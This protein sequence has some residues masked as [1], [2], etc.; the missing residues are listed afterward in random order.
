MILIFHQ[1]DNLNLLG[2]RDYKGR[3]YILL[4]VKLYLVFRFSSFP[5]THA[6]LQRH[7]IV[8]IVLLK[9]C[10]ADKSAMGAS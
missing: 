1:L 5:S 6:D 7:A 9:R 3:T 10:L 2:K 8:C 4:D